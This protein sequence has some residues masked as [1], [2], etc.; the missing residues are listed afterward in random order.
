MPD[1][2][3]IGQDDDAL[4]AKIAERIMA[5]EHTPYA[6]RLAA[7]MELTAVHTMTCR[8]H[9]RGLLGARDAD[10]WHDIF[11]IAAHFDQATNTFKPI[12]RPRYAIDR[13]L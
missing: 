11:G 5:C 7:V 6:D 3:A 4:I 9:L 12:F 2:S 8:L 1:Q 13:P 10:F